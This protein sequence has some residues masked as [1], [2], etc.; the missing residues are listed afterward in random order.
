MELSN[1]SLQ[2]ASEYLGVSQAALRAWKRV[3]K[4]PVFFRAGK[5]LRF[6]RSDLDLW[7][8]ERLVKPKRTQ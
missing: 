4:G 7:I 6:R 8:Q 1:L 3:G 2:Q 5:L